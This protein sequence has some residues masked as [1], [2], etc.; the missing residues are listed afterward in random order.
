MGRHVRAPRR[1]RPAA[2]AAAEERLAEEGGEDVRQAAEVGVHRRIATGAEPGVTEPVV[3]PPALG[4]GEHLVGLRDGAEATLG[5]GR[6]ADVRMELA[7]EPPERPLDVGVARVPGDAQQ[8]VV[9]LLGG[10]HQT[11][12]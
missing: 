4:I 11:G 1:A 2:R 5:V 8:L 6:L 12:P 3:R 7:G 9:V 10:C